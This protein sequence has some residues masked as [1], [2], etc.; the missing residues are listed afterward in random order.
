M[1]HSQLHHLTSDTNSFVNNFRILLD[2]DLKLDKPVNSVVRFCLFYL[3]LLTKVKPFLKHLN[4]WFMHVFWLLQL[5][6]LWYKLHNL[7]TTSDSPKCCCEII[8]RSLQM[9]TLPL[10]LASI[11][12]FLVCFKFYFKILFF[13]V[14]KCLNN[15]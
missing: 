11:H 6:T 5:N 10:I 7:G 13:L 4:G 14:Y 15:L 1:H 8:K 9:T 3:H 12:C 2:S